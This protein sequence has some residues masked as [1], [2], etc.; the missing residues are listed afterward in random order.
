MPPSTSIH[1]SATYAVPSVE[2]I[3]GSVSICMGYLQIFQN[4][5]HYS[6]IEPF[7]ADTHKIPQ[8]CI[9]I[10]R[11]TKPLQDIL[12]SMPLFA[13][14]KALSNILRQQNIL[15]LADYPNLHLCKCLHL[16]QNLYLL[17]KS[18]FS[19]LLATNRTF[20]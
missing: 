13:H 4:Q 18:F 12:K 7:F 17:V 8:Y 3:I 5:N 20:E 14:S 2:H 9:L 1:F 15:R 11:L 19:F 10:V 16:H 6:K